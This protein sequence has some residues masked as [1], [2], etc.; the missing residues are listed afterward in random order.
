MRNYEAICHNWFIV[1]DKGVE[2]DWKKPL[3]QKSQIKTKIKLAEE[4]FS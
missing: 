1:K 2:I 4:P 3:I